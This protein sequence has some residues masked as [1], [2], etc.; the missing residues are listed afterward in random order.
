MLNLKY[1]RNEFVYEQTHKHKEQTCGDHVAG[2][3]YTSVSSVR[4]LGRVNF[5]F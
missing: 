3:Q 2:G 1:D 5:L 4:C